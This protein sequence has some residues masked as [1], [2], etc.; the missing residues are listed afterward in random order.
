MLAGKRGVLRMLEV[1]YFGF[2]VE[3]QDAEA[4]R[5]RKQCSEAPTKMITCRWEVF[6]DLSCGDG[7][8]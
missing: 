4:Q 7:E 3:Q 1:D 2:G 6:L 8:N 5:K